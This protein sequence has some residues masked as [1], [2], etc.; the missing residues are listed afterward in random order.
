MPFQYVIVR[1]LDTAVT[2][3]YAELVSDGWRDEARPLLEE[4]FFLDKACLLAELRSLML[5][6]GYSL[7]RL[8]R[9]DR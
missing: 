5:D 4:F 7:E 2:S 6:L 8:A 3:A 9:F 1:P